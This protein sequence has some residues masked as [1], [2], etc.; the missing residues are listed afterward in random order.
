VMQMDRMIA[1]QAFLNRAES[2]SGMH[3]AWYSWGTML[4]PSRCVSR[5]E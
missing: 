4:P 5:S 1:V 3:P 2:L